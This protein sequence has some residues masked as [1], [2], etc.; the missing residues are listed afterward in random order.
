MVHLAVFQ[1]P[2]AE[3]E[4][5]DFCRHNGKCFAYPDLDSIDRHAANQVSWFQ[6][7]I[8]LVAV[9]PGGLSPLESV[10]LP[11]FMGM[12][13]SSLRCST[14]NARVCPISSSV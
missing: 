1:G 7:Q 2:Q 13:R 3:S 6:V 14:D 8:R 5:E 12:D 10:Y 9:E 4:S 11:G